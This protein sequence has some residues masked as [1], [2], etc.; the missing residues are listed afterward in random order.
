VAEQ[1]AGHAGGVEPAGV[2]AGGDQPLVLLVIGVTLIGD[3][4]SGLLS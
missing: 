3:G 1:Q 2:Q 4:I